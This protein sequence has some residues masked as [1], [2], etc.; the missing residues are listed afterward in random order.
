M[1]DRP[2]TLRRSISIDG[3]AKRSF[4]SGISECPPASSLASSPPWPSSWIASS[5]D[6]GAA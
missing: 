1:P 2:G 4:I 6:A 5:I 3:A